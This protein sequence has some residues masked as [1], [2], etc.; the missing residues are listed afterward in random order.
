MFRI[1]SKRMSW[2]LV[3]TFVLV[4]CGE[5][6]VPVGPVDEERW[7]APESS[8]MGTNFEGVRGPAP[9]HL[10]PYLRPPDTHGAAGPSSLVL[11]T[12]YRIKLVQKDGVELDHS[13]LMAS[14]P[15]YFFGRDCFDP[16][17]IYD[18]DTGRF[19]VVALA[20]D[21]DVNDEPIPNTSRLH[22]A[23]STSSNPAD[24]RSREPG[25]P[26]TGEAWIRYETVSWVND[27]V[28]GGLDVWF[29]YPGLGVFNQGIIVTGNMFTKAKDFRGAVIRV[30]DKAGLIAG[31]STFVD[32]R[33]TD[34]SDG[35][36]G[37]VYTIRPAVH[38]GVTPN[39]GT[40]AYL[41]SREGNTDIRLWTLDDPLVNWPAGLTMIPI[42]LN[43]NNASADA[44]WYAPQKDEFIST[45]SGMFMNAVW[46]NNR[47]YTVITGGFPATS[48]THTVLYWYELLTDTGQLG[49]RGAVDGGRN[50]YSYMP[51]IN[52]DPAGN[53]ALCYATSGPF[54][55]VDVRFRTR[56]PTDPAGALRYR[57][58]VKEST[59]SYRAFNWGDYS[60]NVID[61][62]DGSFW[63]AGEWAVGS[64]SWSTWWANFDGNSAKS[65]VFTVQPSNTPAG[66]TLT[67]E[68]SVQDGYGTTD[69][70][71]DRDIT[72][73][74]GS[75][76]S[77][78]VLS[79]TTTVTAINGVAL[80]DDL[81]IDQP[82]ANYTLIASAQE[83]W[84]AL[85]A[86][87][88]IQ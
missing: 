61:P 30:F 35:I 36:D 68:V 21:L 72:L 62:T 46:R 4:S 58:K 26:D 20:L 39:G 88:D 80:F 41:V 2:L 42:A 71:F 45:V 37:T 13:G 34:P 43:S 83:M 8:G 27:P 5:E 6:E 38:Y 79:G 74:I 32:Y 44:P 86:P 18:E 49:M 11:V 85:S 60:V 59:T 29:D 65:L 17:A 82:G 84:E 47:L 54:N 33:E 10:L 14:E 51:S 75:N 28:F 70:S 25:D 52:I 81:G 48:P 40:I 19:F 87:F 73:Q 76:P 12:N 31:T 53:I 55:Y 57:Q 15:T 22:I 16:K 63:V 1:S 64:Y 69:T 66:S 3:C 77:G 7:D 9:S 24:L 23:V 50:L 67:V 56:R 78:G